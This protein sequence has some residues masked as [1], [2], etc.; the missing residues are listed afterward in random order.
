[1]QCRTAIR[2]CSLY[3]PW[4]MQHSIPLADMG[5]SGGHVESREPVSVT[6]EDSTSMAYRVLRNIH[7]V[8]HG[9][10]EIVLGS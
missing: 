1:M 6:C 5:G 2:E 9:A 8:S 3:A 10:G 7:G 4:H